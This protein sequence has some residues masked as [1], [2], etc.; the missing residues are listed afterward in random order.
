MRLHLATKTGVLHMYVII[1]RRKMLLSLIIIVLCISLVISSIAIHNLV[2]AAGSSLYKDG[3]IQWVD[4]NVSYEALEKAMKLDIESYGKEVKLDWIEMLAYCAAKNG[5]N[6]KRFKTSQLD[7]LAKQ[8]KEGKTMEELT[9]DLKYYPYYLEAYSAVLSG[10][11]GEFEIEV[12]DE[13]SETGKKW[14]KKYGLKAFCPIAKNYYFSHYDDFGNKRDYG[15]TRKHLGNDLMGSVGT[16]II[17]VE[18]GIVEAL[19]WNQ[20]GGWR[21][22]IRSLDRKRYYYY[23]HLRQNF[24]YH[25]DLKEGSIVKAGDVIGYLGRTG[26]S[27]KENTN[28]I[29][30]H[31]LHFGM[32]LVFDESQKESNN[33]IWIDVYNIVKLLSKNK[34][35]V[36]KNPNTKDYNRVYDIKIPEVEAILN[37]QQ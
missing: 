13:A 14:I 36:V 33:E 34:S 7:N 8:L 29:K 9:K 19:G 22:G 31:H 4:F 15:F 35:E 23:A 5:G 28:N 21:I 10:F 17:A 30:Q 16:P 3:I 12:K 18:S 32:Q 24:P 25:K 37:Q 27:T 26:Y 20:Y 11:L 6:F 2:F 1:G